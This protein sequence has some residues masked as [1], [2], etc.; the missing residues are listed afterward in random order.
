MIARRIV[1]ALAMVAIASI[2]GLALADYMAGVDTLSGWMWGV[3]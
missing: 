3:L 2:L 1:E